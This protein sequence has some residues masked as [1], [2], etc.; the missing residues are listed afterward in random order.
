MIFLQ[1]C[2]EQTQSEETSNEESILLNHTEVNNVDSNNETV[3]TEVST[4]SNKDDDLVKKEEPWAPDIK[5][6]LD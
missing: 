2:G 1:S 3:S 4:E 6:E 5:W